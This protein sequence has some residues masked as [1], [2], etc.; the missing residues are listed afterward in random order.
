LV[1]AAIG[2]G[3]VISLIFSESLG[4]AAGGMVVPG[5][6]ALYIHQPFAVLGTV[7]ASLLTLG[8]LK[9]L[10]NYVLIFGRRR[11][12][13]SVLI[14]FLFGWMAKHLF[15]IP[16]PTYTLELN[17]IGYIIPG[18]IANWME[19]QGAGRTLCIMIITAVIVRLILM[20]ISGE[21]IPNEVAY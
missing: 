15:V 10:T 12:V 7:I 14:G 19:R 17:S 18:L 1:E 13:F 4:L 5:Y 6:I 2:L 9:L 11:I 16:F 8:V 20:L 21:V 3:L